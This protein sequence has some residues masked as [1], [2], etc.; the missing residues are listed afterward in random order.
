MDG[1]EATKIL[2]RT[3]VRSSRQ[4]FADLAVFLR[5]HAQKIKAT[6][7]HG[8]FYLE[9]RR[10]ARAEAFVVAAEWIEDLVNRWAA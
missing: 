1:S 7:S 8:S 3:E 5:S 10:E 6:N 2:E 9:S 4:E